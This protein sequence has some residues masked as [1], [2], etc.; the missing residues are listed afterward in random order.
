[1]AKLARSITNGAIFQTT[2]RKSKCI[3]RKWKEH[4]L[5]R[6]SAAVKEAVGLNE[7]ARTYKIPKTPTEVGKCGS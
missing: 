4:D 7:A 6:A 3:Y 2:T 5:R 1:V